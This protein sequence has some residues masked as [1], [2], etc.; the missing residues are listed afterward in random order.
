[1]DKETT[2]NNNFNIERVLVR[3]RVTEKVTIN[4][5]N[6]V[7]VFDVAIDANKFQI[8]EAVEKLYNVIPMKVNITTVPAKRIVYRGKKGIKSQGKK[9]YVYL[10]EG[11]KISIV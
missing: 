6:N 7:Y 3:P 4:A 1:M 5:E 11:D 8:K 9:A 2:Q 10:K